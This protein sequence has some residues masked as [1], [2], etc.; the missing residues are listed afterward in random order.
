MSWGKK[1]KTGMKPVTR[2]RAE[3]NQEYQHI[4]FRV[5]HKQRLIVDNEFENQ[6]LEKEIEEHLIE[7]RR[8]D[9]EYKNV[10]PATPEP[11]VKAD[12]APAEV[13]NEGA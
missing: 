4:A 13:P 2:K 5:G 1:N 9:L 10:P 8:L 6:R 3:I 11:E 7:L 12:A